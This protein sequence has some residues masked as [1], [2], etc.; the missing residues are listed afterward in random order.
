MASCREDTAGSHN[1]G[2]QWNNSKRH[3]TANDNSD[4]RKHKR[5]HFL[6]KGCLLHP[7]GSHTKQDCNLW[8]E[9]VQEAAQ[10]SKQNTKYRS[11]NLCWYCKKEEYKPEHTCQEYLNFKKQKYVANRAARIM[12][13]DDSDSML[14]INMEKLDL[15]KQE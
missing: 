7:K 5:G 11:T 3:Y 1:M 4:H 15:Q 12:D 2:E 14:P 8:K 6:K 9:I 10:H 13:V